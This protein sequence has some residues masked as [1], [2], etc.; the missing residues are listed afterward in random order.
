MS[1][2]VDAQKFSKYLNQAPVFEVPGRTFPVDAKYLEDAVQLTNFK[3]GEINGIGIEDEDVDQEDEGPSGGAAND[4]L[5]EKLDSFTPATR[6]TMSKLNEYRIPYEL[7][8]KLLQSIQVGALSN[9][10]KATLVFLPG[11]AEI[12]RLNDMLHGNP[13]FARQCEIFALHSSIATEDQERAF[14]PPPRDMR[15]IVL[16]TNIAET[17][18]T[19]PDITCVIDTGKHKEMR[20]D[21]RRQ[22]SR[23]IEAFISQANALQ[24]RGR[25]GRVQKGLCFHLFSKQ[26]FQKMAPEQTPEML[27]LSL[28]DLVLRVKI[29]NLGG[30]DE[31]LSEALDPPSSKNVR[32]AIDALKDVKALTVSQDLTSLG[33]QLARLPLDV[34][35]GKLLLLGTIFGCLDAALTIAS[36]LSSKSPFVS[37]MGSRTQADQ[38]RLSFK[39]GDSDLLTVYNA[40]TAW[41]RICNSNGMSEQQF[42][43]KNCLS[44]Q[45]F[46]N[47]EDLKGQLVTS[48]IDA[49]FI[50]MSSEERS[51]LNKARYHYGRRTFVEVPQK[52]NINNS[53][54][55]IINST[56]A[57]SFYPKLLKRE[58]NGWR[59]VANNQ[60]ISLHPTSVNKRPDHHLKWLSFYHIM[61]SSSKFYNAHET[62]AVEDMAVALLCGEAEFKMY[63]GVI[64]I[65]GNRIKFSV[66][67]P[68]TML[69]L[70]TL[71]NG[72]RAVVEQQIRYP[73]R[74][75]SEKH[76]QIMGVWQEMFTREERSG[77]S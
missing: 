7:I 34:F 43:R 42:C 52:Y 10:S 16:A 57:M 18:I 76:Q 73:G 17:G 70:K 48:L 65:D 23:L 40:Y 51:T 22:L 45:T 44:A 24:R 67:E 71:R 49:R 1:A 63:A 32:R 20:F 30:I 77:T 31:T 6:N 68:K 46:S 58:G 50:A 36:I 61:Q 27:R 59:N 66:K 72:I 12:R 69:A 74:P 64:V 39:K 62:N 47:V 54:D 53:N 3:V 55:L 9:Y 25:A 19:I 41:R 26:R 2:T 8:V 4:T 33:K 11:I 60:A 75:S 56:I 15:K 14:L 35:L 13:A 28:Q 5:V 38:S 29:C 37:T 21:E